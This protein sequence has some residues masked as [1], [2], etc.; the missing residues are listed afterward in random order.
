MTE[1]TKICEL[2]FEKF[3]LQRVAVSDQKPLQLLNSGRTS[4]VS[5]NLGYKNASAAALLNGFCFSE[6]FHAVLPG[7][8]GE[9]QEKIIMELLQREQ[10]VMQGTSEHRFLLDFAKH[11]TLNAPGG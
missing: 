8:S 9:C 5:V 10:V 2:L 6:E 1:K 11:F 4:G 3:G 7:I